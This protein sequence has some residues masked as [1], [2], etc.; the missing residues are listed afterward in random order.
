MAYTVIWMSKER[1][2]GETPFSSRNLALKHAKDHFPAQ[3]NSWGVDR[4]EVR[5][6]ADTLIFHHPR[7]L[8]T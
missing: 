2:V 3:Q 4:V 1:R 8:R 6:E 5:D 7:M